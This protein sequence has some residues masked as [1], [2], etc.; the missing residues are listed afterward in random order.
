M[1]LCVRNVSTHWHCVD[2][3]YLLRK[4]LLNKLIPHSEQQQFRHLR[5]IDKTVSISHFK[6]LQLKLLPCSKKVP[7]LNPGQGSL[8][9]EFAC[10]PHTCLGSLWLP[11]TIQKHDC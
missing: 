6:L 1:H 4:H 7:G 10:S 5:L 2:I 9:I 8:C 11:P 3:R